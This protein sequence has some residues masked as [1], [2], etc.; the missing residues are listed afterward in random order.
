MKKYTISYIMSKFDTE[1][2]IIVHEDNKEEAWLGGLDAIRAKYGRDAY[3]A[4]VSGVTYKN[5]DVHYFR[6]SAG[7]PY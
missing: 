3:A 6:T 1:K 4:W 2:E 5:G 7:N